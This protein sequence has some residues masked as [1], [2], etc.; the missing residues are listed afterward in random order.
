VGF[1]Y[2]GVKP[3]PLDKSATKQAVSRNTSELMHTGKYPQ[4]QAIA[5]ALD[6]KRRAAGKKGGRDNTRPK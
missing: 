3:M 5:I 4:R 2:I 6:V 1:F